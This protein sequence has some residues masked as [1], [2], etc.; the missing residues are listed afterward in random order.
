MVTI[1]NQYLTIIRSKRPF[2][3]A[4]WGAM[5]SRHLAALALLTACTS[6]AS[7]KSAPAPTATTGASAPATLEWPTP[8]GWRSEK[9]GFPLQFAPSLPYRGVEELRFAPRFFDPKSATYFTYSF[10]WLIDDAR[11]LVL[12]GPRLSADLTTYFAGLARAVDA[13][14]FDAKAHRSAITADG[15]AYRGTVT[16]VDAFNASR[17]IELAVAGERVRCAG[18]RVAIVLSLSPRTDAEVWSLLEGQRRTLRC[19]AVRSSG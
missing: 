14:R 4:T 18:G 7:S 6:C 16:T 3:R 13:E 5:H 15:D 10:A 19:D 8:A 11:E 1:G 17:P 2:V 12:D 9:L